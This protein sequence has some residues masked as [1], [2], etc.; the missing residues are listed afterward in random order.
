[1]DTIRSREEEKHF[2]IE[3]NICNFFYN[4]TH[5]S[6]HRSAFIQIKC[7]LK[8]SLSQVTS[9]NVEFVCAQS[10]IPFV[11][12]S[13]KMSCNWKERRSVL[14]RSN[15]VIGPW[16]A[17]CAM[18]SRR[19]VLVVCVVLMT[20]RSL[21]LLLIFVLSVQ[22]DIGRSFLSFFDDGKKASLTLLFLSRSLKCACA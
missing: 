19:Y 7:L 18:L 2:S 9:G 20:F 14:K 16:W 11:E 6:L 22:K 4:F 21:M 8:T 13:I 5:F 1:M 15:H 10:R 12:H 17:M 3:L